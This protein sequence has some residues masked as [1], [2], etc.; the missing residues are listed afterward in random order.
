MGTD[1]GCTC[2]SRTCRL[3]ESVYCAPDNVRR[4]CAPS[5]PDLKKKSLYPFPTPPKPKSMLFPKK[6]YAHT[7]KS[8]F[9]SEADTFPSYF[10]GCVFIISGS[11]GFAR[12]KSVASPMPP[13]A[14][15]CSS[16][17]ICLQQHTEG[18]GLRAAC[19]SRPESVWT[20]VR[21]HRSCRHTSSALP[22]C[23]IKLPSQVSPHLE[24]RAKNC[25]FLKS[26]IR[27]YHG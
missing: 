15:N 10:S 3:A 4:H 21:S 17:S 26:A 20:M 8:A 24:M 6:A 23:I 25:P 12:L 13:C 9:I 16:Y 22:N 5:T 11:Q 18:P 7:A 27:K 19:G 2:V 1:G 14:H